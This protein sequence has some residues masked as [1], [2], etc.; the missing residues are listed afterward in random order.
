[1]KRSLREILIAS[2]VA[3]TTIAAL[4][5]WF[6]DS[7]FRGLWPLLGRAVEWLFTAVAIFDIPYFSFTVVD[8]SILLISAYYFYAAIVSFSA[9]WIVSRWVYGVGPLRSL[10]AYGN[11]LTC[12]RQ[13]V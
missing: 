8:R 1:M 3:A 2:H 4:L 13:D 5:L 9:A 12:W 11:K 6:M 7:I 10:V